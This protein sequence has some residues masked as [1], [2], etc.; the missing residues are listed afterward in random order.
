MPFGAIRNGQ[1]TCAEPTA[2]GNAFLSPAGEDSLFQDTAK[3]LRH[4]NQTDS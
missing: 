2:E 1:Y 4:E 3:T